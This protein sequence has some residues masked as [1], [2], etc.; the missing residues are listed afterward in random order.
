MK[1]ATHVVL[2]VAVVRIFASLAFAQ[3]EQ[4]PGCGDPNTKFAVKTTKS[5]HSGHLNATQPDSRKALVYFVEDDT[6]FESRPKPTTR[7]GVDGQWVGALT[8][9]RI[10]SSQSIP[11]SIICAP[12]RKLQSPCF[13]VARPPQLTSRQKP[14]ARISS[15]PKTSGSSTDQPI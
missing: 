2:P 6:G 10:S 5:Q 8:A 1:K 13:W 12:A 3:D 9:T 11:E 7:I 15:R 14:D 4:L